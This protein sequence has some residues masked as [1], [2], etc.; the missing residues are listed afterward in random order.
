MTVIATELVY[1]VVLF[2]LARLNADLIKH[3]IPVR[4]RWNAAVHIACWLYSYLV[5]RDEVAMVAYPFL[6]LLMFDTTLNLMRGKK[7]DYVTKTPTATVDKWAV[8]V[9]GQDGATP[10]AICATVVVFINVLV[11]IL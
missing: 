7:W 4:H 9:F 2:V 5:H 11:L 10:K 8:A 6:G 3:D 1:I